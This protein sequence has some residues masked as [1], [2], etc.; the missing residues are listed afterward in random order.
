MTDGYN[1]D[2]KGSFGLWRGCVN[3]IFTLKQIREK[4]RDKKQRVYVG[5]I[6]MEKAYDRV[7]KEAILQVLRIYDMGGKV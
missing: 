3:Q 1:D 4:I 6:N 7:N 5:F 2:K